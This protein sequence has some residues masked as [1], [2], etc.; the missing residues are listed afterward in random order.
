MVDLPQCALY[1]IMVN[2][3]FLY[4][5]NSI[6][7]KYSVQVLESCRI[8][9]WFIS[10]ASI[11]SNI[12]SFRTSY[13]GQWKILLISE[14]SKVCQLQLENSSNFIIF[15]Y[16]AIMGRNGKMD[17]ILLGLYTRLSSALIVS[18][19]ILYPI[20]WRCLKTE[21]KYNIQLD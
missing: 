16:K 15:D 5:C 2:Y 10:A 14:K 7:W 18:T 21:N 19:C 8:L 20:I 1:I 6:I 4:P 17:L 9:T 13:I 3:R 12:Q 11:P